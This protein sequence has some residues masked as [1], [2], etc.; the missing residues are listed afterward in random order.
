MEYSDLIAARYSVRA[1]RPDPVEDE[2]LQAVLEAARLAPTAANRQPFQLVVMHTA[3]RKEEIGEIYRRPWFVQAPLVI[4]VCAISSQAWVRESDRF[5]ARL[6]DAAIVADH[7]ILAAANQGL[8]TCWVAAFNV[9][10]ARKVLQLPQEAEPIIFTPLGYP[11]D[12]PGP[13]I[14]KPLSELVRYEHW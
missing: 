10:V 8:G 13:K 2:K 11:A 4:A 3:G 1:Y 5:N 6:V 12:S 14:R 7:L 9:D